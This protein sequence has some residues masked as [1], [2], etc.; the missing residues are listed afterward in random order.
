[1]DLISY[2]VSSLKPTLS[3][4]E[5]CPGSGMLCGSSFLN[6]IFQKFIKNKLSALSGWD[7]EI[8][9]EAMK[10]FEVVVK[11]QFRGRS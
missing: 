4:E 9:E 11:Q 8:L 3:I 7:D 6:R 5:A 1:M 2:K 10:R